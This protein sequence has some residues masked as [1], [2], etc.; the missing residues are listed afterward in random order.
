MAKYK[1]DRTRIRRNLSNLLENKGE[2]V[3]SI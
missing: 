2:A 3:L 1:I